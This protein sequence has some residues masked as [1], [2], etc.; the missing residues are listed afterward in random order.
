MNFIGPWRRRLTSCKLQGFFLFFSTDGSKTWTRNR[1]FKFYV[2]SWLSSPVRPS[3]VTRSLTSHT[4]C[5]NFIGFNLGVVWSSPFWTVCCVSLFVCVCL[6]LCVC[7]T[8]IPITVRSIHQD[9]I[10]SL[11]QQT[12]FL[13]EAYFSSVEKIVLTTLEVSVVGGSL[14]PL[15]TQH[16]WRLRTQ[17]LRF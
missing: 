16:L 9:K 14:I 4:S 11:R 3:T 5:M 15:L 6:C 12:Q 17:N 7:A 8:Q 10:L 13:W 2:I 1:K